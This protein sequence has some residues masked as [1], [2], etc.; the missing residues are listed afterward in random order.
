LRWKRPAGARKVQ[1]RKK[2]ESLVVGKIR[3]QSFHHRGA[4]QKAFCVIGYRERGSAST[5]RK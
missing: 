3:N 5:K 2:N 1:W 4:A